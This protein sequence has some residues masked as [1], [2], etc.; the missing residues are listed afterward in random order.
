MNLDKLGHFCHW[1][2][3]HSYSFNGP[4]ANFDCPVGWVGYTDLATLMQVAQKLHS[5]LLKS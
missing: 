1:D 2:F 4:W 5:S 3:L